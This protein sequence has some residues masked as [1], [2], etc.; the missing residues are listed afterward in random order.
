M[1]LKKEY[2]R[3]VTWNG[4]EVTA[5][6]IQHI[7]FI[8][9]G[10]VPRRISCPA[11]KEENTVVQVDSNLKR[12]IDRWRTSAL[13]FGNLKWWGHNTDNLVTQQEVNQLL[14]LFV[15]RGAGEGHLAMVKPTKKT[16]LYKSVDSIS[17]WPLSSAL[18]FC[19]LRSLNSSVWYETI[20]SF[21]HFLFRFSLNQL[22]ENDKFWR[23]EIKSSFQ[24]R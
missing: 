4:D 15:R 10:A 17:N 16:L 11:N 2:C 9:W 3:V 23:N 20:I 6:I 13:V 24:R 14:V 18:V 21:H 8:G 5:E 22:R 19:A 12:P 1:N 7:L